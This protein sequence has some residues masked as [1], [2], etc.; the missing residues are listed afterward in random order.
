MKLPYVS[1]TLQT[2]HLPLCATP[3]LGPFVTEV[4]VASKTTVRQLKLRIQALSKTRAGRARLDPERVVL[5][6]KVPFRQGCR[7]VSEQ[8]VVLHDDESIDSYRIVPDRATLQ[9]KVKASEPGA[10][11]PPPWFADFQNEDSLGSRREPPPSPR[12]D[13]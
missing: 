5:T 11:G 3:T 2:Y 12:R 1:L 4:E 7:R 6:L 13:A 10:V 9:L 8:A